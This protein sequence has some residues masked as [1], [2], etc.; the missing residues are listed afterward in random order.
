M[1]YVQSS[2]INMIVYENNTS[3]GKHSTIIKNLRIE[4]EL[5]EFFQWRVFHT[6]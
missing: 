1:Y 2:I 5:L 3:H 4:F 6:V